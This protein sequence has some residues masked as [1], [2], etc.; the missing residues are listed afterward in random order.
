MGSTLWEGGM[1]GDIASSRY[2]LTGREVVA[3]LMQR[4]VKVD[5]KVRF[6]L[7]LW[8]LRHSLQP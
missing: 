7:L 1:T 5:G 3:I 4:H 2:A 8:L 6:L